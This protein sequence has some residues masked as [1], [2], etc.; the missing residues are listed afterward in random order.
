MNLFDGDCFESRAM[1]R[2]RTRREENTNEGS[3]FSSD[4]WLPSL[5]VT[6]LKRIL[7]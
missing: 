1:K 5:H 4:Q 3:D 7:D 6:R 2:V